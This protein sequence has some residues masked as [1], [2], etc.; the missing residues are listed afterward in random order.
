MVENHGFFTSLYVSSILFGLYQVSL[1]D[2]IG[3]NLDQI[4]I[5]VF[6][7]IIPSFAAGLFLGFFFYK[8]GWSLLG[9]IT[10]RIGIRFFLDPLPIVSPASAPPWWL[11][12]TLETTSYIIIIF[13]VDS[14][15][16]EPGYVRRRYGLE[17]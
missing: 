14:I 7:N 13:I 17:D 15:I 11:A 9:P 6:T 10:F 5:Y 12:L 4:G 2:V 8:L 3:A 1:R 16:K